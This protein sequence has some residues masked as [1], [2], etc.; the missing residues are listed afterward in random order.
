MK[1]DYWRKTVKKIQ[2]ARQ[3]GSLLK[4]R[5]NRALDFEFDK[6]EIF[7]E[8]VSGSVADSP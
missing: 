5:A 8:G 1:Q 2:I 4:N 3:N 7:P 6:E